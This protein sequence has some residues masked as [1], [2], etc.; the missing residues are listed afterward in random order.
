MAQAKSIYWFDELGLG[1]LPFVG[2]KNA[3]LGEL[4]SGMKDSGVLVPTGFAISTDVYKEF[5]RF[6]GLVIPIADELWALEHES[7]SL[8]EVGASI[9]SL[10]MAAKFSDEQCASIVEA[11]EQLCRRVGNP[12][13]DVAVRSSAS[14]E[15]LPEAS[16]AGQQDS[17]LNIRGS[18]RLLA[19][20]LKCYVSLYTD[21]AIAYRQEQGFDG[22]DIALSVGVQQMVRSDL[23]CAGVMF[24]LDT[25]NGFPA[26][27]VINGA[28]GLGEG[29]EIGRAHV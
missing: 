21:R 8:A 22:Q 19:A 2:G 27:I 18:E 9:R 23:A 5:F 15:D 7:K 29:V 26:V 25:D 17:Y 4:A 16:F 1:D 20:C 12:Q 13:G 11:Y 3:S 14:V 10:I 24:T 28:W 6:N